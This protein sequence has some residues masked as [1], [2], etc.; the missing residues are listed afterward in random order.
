MRV[1]VRTSYGSSQAANQHLWKLRRK[2]CSYTDSNFILNGSWISHFR[3]YFQK[4]KTAFIFS[5]W[6]SSKKI[7]KNS[8]SIFFLNYRLKSPRRLRYIIYGN[9]RKERHLKMQ[10]GYYGT[11]L[12]TLYSLKLGFNLAMWAKSIFFLRKVN[13]SKP[14][15][16]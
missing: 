10:I 12:L 9:A 15:R 11:V 5:R 8:N 2:K 1:H 4:M 7:L 3:S 6:T 16:Q 13:I 14:Q